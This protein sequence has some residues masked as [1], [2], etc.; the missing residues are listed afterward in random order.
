MK[1]PVN[2]PVLRV[3][4]GLYPL[5]E[6]ARSIGGEKATIVDV[7][8]PGSNPLT[9]SPPA[10]G[11][12]GLVIEIGGGFQT[13]FESVAGSAR[14]VL[15]LDAGLRIDDPY[16]WLD[17]TTMGKVA[18]LIATAMESADPSAAPLFRQNT[19][20]LQAQISSEGQD[21]SST[22]STCRISTMVT[23]DN[24]FS[25]MAADYGL[26][27]EVAGTSAGTSRVSNVA[28]VVEQRALGSVFSEP[29]VSNAGV[30]AVAGLANVGL[31]RLD[32]LAGEPAAGYPK[33]TDYFGLMEEDL[34]TISSVLACSVDEQ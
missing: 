3:V 5:A 9:Y 14:R 34:S 2:A 18:N 19:E 27:D 31:K 30:Q 4:T 13:G 12:P 17:P 16:V 33:G 26:D 15:A 32:T 11:N 7:V 20:S 29:W 6:A 10:F 23:P 8:P 28:A 24:A 21:Y 25:A 22:L 1:V